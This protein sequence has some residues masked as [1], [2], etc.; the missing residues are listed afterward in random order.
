M[1]VTANTGSDN[2]YCN[3]S[4]HYHYSHYELQ[5]YLQFAECIVIK[6]ANNF[7]LNTVWVFP[8]QTTHSLVFKALNTT[9]PQMC[10]L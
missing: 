2:T 10:A 3:V 4:G 6:A 8:D 1:L 7:E 5:Q 9:N